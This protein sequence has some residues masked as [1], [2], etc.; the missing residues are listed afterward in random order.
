MGELRMERRALMA[1]IFGG[2]T[3]ERRRF[4]SPPDIAMQ[5]ARE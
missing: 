3:S 2:A 5:Y 1:L 4:A